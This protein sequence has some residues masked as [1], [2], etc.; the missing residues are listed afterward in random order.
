[1]GIKLNQAKSSLCLALFQCHFLFSY[2]SFC[3]A[4]PESRGREGA[5]AIENSGCSVAW[6]GEMGCV[7]AAYISLKLKNIC[8]PSP[9]NL[10]GGSWRP[11]PPRHRWGRGWWSRGTCCC[12]LSGR[13]WHRP[14]TT[15]IS[16]LGSVTITALYV[17]RLPLWDAVSITKAR[18]FACR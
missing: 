7:G 2:G 13:A 6:K 5:T 9:G 10:P 4:G 11:A 15:S 14:N 17:S 1:M 12:R 18:R 16:G 8:S 3:A